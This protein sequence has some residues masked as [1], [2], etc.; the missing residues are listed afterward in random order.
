[1]ELAVRGWKVGTLVIR[2]Q[3]LMIVVK[4]ELTKKTKCRNKSQYFE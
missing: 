2:K 3:D 4:Q 1:M